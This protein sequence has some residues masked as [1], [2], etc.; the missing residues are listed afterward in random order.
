[1]GKYRDGSPILFGHDLA[2]IGIFGILKC[3]WKCQL[4]LIMQ[5]ILWT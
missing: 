5:S 4:Y 2:E 1:M 3:L